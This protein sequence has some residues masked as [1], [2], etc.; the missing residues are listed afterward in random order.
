[1]N[2]APKG[3]PAIPNKNP[4]SPAMVWGAQ[5][6]GTIAIAIAIYLFFGG[7]G[8]LIQGADP[9]WMRFGLLGILAASLPAL[10]YLRG[11]KS[12]LVSDITAMRSR[13]GTPDPQKRA[14]LLRQLAIGGA[15]SE[16]P[17]ALGVIYLLAGGEPRWFVTAA[18]VTVALRLSYRP[19]T[20][21][22]P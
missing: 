4:P 17:L 19:F 13:G 12:A 1:V 8:P 18:A 5:L 20:S 21:S 15:L 16:I 14:A 6:A 9:E 22:S 10:W 3:T 2:P 11:Y 7:V